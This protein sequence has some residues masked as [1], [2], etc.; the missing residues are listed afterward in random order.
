M[1]DRRLPSSPSAVELNPDGRSERRMLFRMLAAALV[2][3]VALG[4][5]IDAS[6]FDTDLMQSWTRTLLDA[7]LGQ[8]YAVAEG[9]DHLPGDLWF[10]WLIGHGLE[11]VGFDNAPRGP[12][13]ALMKFVPAVAD[14]V[15]AW[16]LF[17]L[18]RRF[19]TSRAALI[20]AGAFAFNPG[21][22]F[23]TSIWGQ[24][25]AVSMALLLG[26]A[27]IVLKT[28]SPLGS[29]SRQSEVSEEPPRPLVNPTSSAALRAGILR[30]AQDDGGR[31]G[32]KEGQTGR[33]AVLESVPLWPVAVPLFTWALLIKP[34]LALVAG[35]FLL[36]A[37]VRTLQESP[38]VRAGL[39]RVASALIATLVLGIATALL[40]ILPFDVG[41]PGMPTR[42][43]VLERAQF[44][45]DLYP[46]TTLQAANIWMVKDAHLYRPSDLD[47][48]LLGLTERT[49][50]SVLLGIA[51]AWIGAIV[52]TRWRAAHVPDVALLVQLVVS[53]VIWA[54]LATSYA[55]FM[56]PTRVHERYFFPVMVLALALAGLREGRPVRWTGRESASAGAGH[57]FQDRLR[58]CPYRIGFHP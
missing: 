30:Q 45:L 15:I 43:M 35:V 34:P 32:R 10:L 28:T 20:V 40:I 58:S 47:G 6:G 2:L 12:F 16:E 8:F 31:S 41:L 19:A 36:Y 51:L 57:S 11:L 53:L 17:V 29:G 56:L 50:G 39:G 4:S 52:V 21:G 49:W 33:Y 18:V 42:W 46:F 9:P 27:L 25:D 44:A 26:G 13:V 7:P 23:L 24:W 5:S 38:S 37:C 55:I 1:Q 22:I 54:A 48:T 3:R 14:T